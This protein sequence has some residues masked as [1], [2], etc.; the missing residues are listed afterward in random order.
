[1]P[2]KLGTRCMMKKGLAGQYYV[3]AEIW[4]QGALLFYPDGH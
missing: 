3:V 1:M 4:L 2:V